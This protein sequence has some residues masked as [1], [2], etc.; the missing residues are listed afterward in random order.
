[1]ILCSLG[2]FKIYIYFKVNLLELLLKMK[3]LED[4]ESK[5]YSINMDEICTPM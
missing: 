3:K 2:A 5:Y 4:D 1:M